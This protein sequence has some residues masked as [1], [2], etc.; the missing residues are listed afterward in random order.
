V[1]GFEV[2]KLLYRGVSAARFSSKEQLVPIGSIVT[3]LN[4]IFIAVAV[5]D[6]LIAK[7]T[8]IWVPASE[9]SE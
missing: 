7:T 4:F 5:I 2:T 8:D 9:R 3:L 6:G 1:P